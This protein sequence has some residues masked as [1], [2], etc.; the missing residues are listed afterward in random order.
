[1]TLVAGSYERFLFGYHL[2]NASLEGSPPKNFLTYPAHQG[3]VRSMAC[4]GALVVSGGSDD[5]F[6]TFD[7]SQSRDLGSQANPAQGAV[8]AVALFAPPGR[9]S[10]QH[11]LTGAAGGE[12]AVWARSGRR[13]SQ[14]WTL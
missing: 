3:P 9:V 7:L 14:P 10:P 8:T 12:I 1:M 6:H 13:A 2:S 5:T 11:L 4:C